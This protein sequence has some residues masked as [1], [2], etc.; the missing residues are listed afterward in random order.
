MVTLSVSG[1]TELWLTR[2]VGAH[3]LRKLG[4]VVFTIFNVIVIDLRQCSNHLAGHRTVGGSFYAK[5]SCLSDNFEMYVHTLVTVF[6]KMAKDQNG[7]PI[8]K[9]SV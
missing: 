1:R 9:R 3:S 4:Y 7:R 6:I 8:I 5:S 2:L